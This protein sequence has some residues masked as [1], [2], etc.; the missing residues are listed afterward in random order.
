MTV[1]LEIVSS[2]RL[3]LND[4]TDWLAFS[5]RGQAAAR[6]FAEEWKRIACLFQKLSLSYSTDHRRPH[7][8]LL[9]IKDFDGDVFGLQRALEY[10]RLV[11]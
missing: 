11:S 5:C 8:K 10:P 2:S 4:L 9:E 6:R 7:Y 3:W 1:G